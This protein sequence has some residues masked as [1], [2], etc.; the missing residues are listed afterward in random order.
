VAGGG[1]GIA[2]AR[3]LLARARCPIVLVGVGA[4]AHTAAIR[5]LVAGTQIPVFMTYKAKGLV[6]DSGP[7]SAGVFTGAGTDGALLAAADLILAIGLDSIELIPNRWDHPAPVIALAEY[8]DPY[9]YLIP[10]VTMLGPLAESL[11]ALPPLPDSWPPAAG[12][13]FRESILGALLAGPE[14]EQGIAPTRLVATVRAAAP[15]NSVA[16]VDAGAHMLA[17]MAAW[18]TEEPGQV[19]ISSGLATM[20]YAVPAA[21]GAALARPHARVFCFVGDGGLMMALGELETI[22][23]LNLP[24]TVVVFDDRTLSLIKLKQRAN[25]QGGAGAV[26][27]TAVDFAAVANGLGLAARSIATI[28]DLEAALADPPSGPQLLAVRVD[29]GSYR[30]VID[31][32]RFGGGRS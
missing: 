3:P 24:V 22:V 27:Y 2:D 14:P 11:A 10:T 12:R 30:Q 4:R 15:A 18:T 5:T 13:Q 16:T 31:V 7:N 8:L 23:R 25:D 1:A 32:T 20:A 26:E 29:P 28:A 21:V 17:A 19:L 6:P 9:R